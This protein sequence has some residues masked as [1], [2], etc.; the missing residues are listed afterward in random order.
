AVGAVEAVE[1]APEAIVAEK[2][3]LSWLKAQGR[4]G[5]ARG[6]LGKPVEGAAGEEEGGEQ[7]AQGD[8][9]GEVFGGPGGRREVASEE[10]LELQAVEEAADDGRGAD[11][12]GFEGGQVK[13][14]GHR[15]LSA[16]DFGREGCYGGRCEGGKQT[17]GS[18]KIPARL[19]AARAS[20]A[21]IF[22]LVKARGRA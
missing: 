2:G 15:C 19:R 13:G 9:G 22:L 1:A 17:R 3:S 14:G 5:A 11:F 16:G 18:K 4:G 21:G 7:D 12:E 20:L 6:P 8:G 10:R